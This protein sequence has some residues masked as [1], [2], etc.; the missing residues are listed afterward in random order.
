MASRI[1][2]HPGIVD[3]RSAKNL[4]K[5]HGGEWQGG[6]LL[7]KSRQQ[8]MQSRM[9][10]GDGQAIR[11]EAVASRVAA[12]IEHRVDRLAALGDGI[13]PAMVAEFLRRLQ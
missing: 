10:Q 3:D 12:G 11:N 5:A 2:L 1:E 9:S 6:N 7:T 4:W 8:D 13:V